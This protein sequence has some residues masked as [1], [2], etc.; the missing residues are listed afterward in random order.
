M[1]PC[2]V[3]LVVWGLRCVRASEGVYFVALARGNNSVVKVV[4]EAKGGVGRSGLRG[5]V[6]ASYWE[7]EL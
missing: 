7:C 6:C 3:S 5:V 1:R 2:A 4:G